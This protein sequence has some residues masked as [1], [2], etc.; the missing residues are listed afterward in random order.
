MSTQTP[1]AFRIGR[2]STNDGDRSLD[3]QIEDTLAL[4]TA[5]DYEDGGWFGAIDESGNT[6]TR[7]RQ[8]KG[9]A[10]TL[11]WVKERV[12]WASQTFPGRPLRIVA[13][14][15][16]RLW[17]DVSEK[18]RIRRILKKLP[19]AKTHTF[20]GLRD[21][22]SASDTFVSTV[23]TG[24]DQHFSDVTREN[25]IRAQ[26]ARRAYGLPGTGWPGYGHRKEDAHKDCRQ[27]VPCLCRWVKVPEEA[28]EIED[29][30]A[31]LLEG[32][33]I[34]A[35][36]RDMNDRKVP[37]RRNRPAWATTTVR[38]MV[39]AP[40]LAGIPVHK[41]KELVATGII[42][43]IIDEITL[44]KVQRLF[45]GRLVGSGVR[46]G[47]L[48]LT[49]L[50]TCNACGNGLNGTMKEGIRRYHCRHCW[51]VFV[52]ADV[53]ESVV[54]EL[55]FLTLNDEGFRRG[56]STAPDTGDTLA[57]IESTEA[58]IATLA[59]AAS[60]IPTAV[61]VAKAR[62]LAEQLDT[63]RQRLRATATT[64]TAATWVADLPRLTAEWEEL[65]PFAKR[66]VI[67]DVLGPITVLPGQ[68]G[69][70]ATRA[71]VAARLLPATAVPKAS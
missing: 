32:E 1:L 68:R 37:T 18:E 63:L 65:E 14:K 71:E 15:D 54:T 28:R 48:L 55:L 52:K 39:T 43:P 35:V 49:G 42:E 24:V 31:R 5:N 60:V 26:E 57:A 69:G 25:V 27:G 47:Q 11:T 45:A 6:D 16:S 51:G 19:D 61:Y 59:E 21:P 22:N 30:I 62:H 7:E 10:P 23:L 46:S 41:G 44:R 17:R 29:I 2:Y 50:L 53:V 38:K 34:N 3:R 20:D 33:P 13:W 66:R 12:E 4:C 8:G 56:L 40:R 70:K 36:V 9:E 58:E 64:S 67:S